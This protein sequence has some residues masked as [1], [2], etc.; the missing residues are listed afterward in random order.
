MKKLVI[1]LMVFSI[2]TTCSPKVSTPEYQIEYPEDPSKKPDSNNSGS[3]PNEPI[4]VDPDD[5]NLPFRD[6]VKKYYNRGSTNFYFGCTPHNYI[7]IADYPKSIEITGIQR[8]FSY[9]TPDN[10][11]KQTLLH[12]SP[13]VYASAVNLEK[14]KNWGKFA[15]DNGMVIR[16]HGPASPQCSEWASTTGRTSTELEQNLRE[17]I[18]YLFEII[19]PM[20]DVVKW[21]D[22][23]NE[24]ISTGLV[25]D[26][27]APGNPKP[28]L[29]P[30][31]SW[32][33]PLTSNTAFQNPWPIIG[34]LPADGFPDLIKIGGV[35]KYI[36]I[37]FE[38]ATQKASPNI[39]LL[40]NQHGANFGGEI[41][42]N[43]K[44][45]VNYLRSRGYRVDA[46]G[47]QA[48]VNLGWTETQSNLDNLSSF[49]D[50]CHENDLEFHLTEVNINYTNEAQFLN[51]ERQANT[52]SKLIETVLKKRHTGI[53]GVNF[54]YYHDESSGT[55]VMMWR[56]DGSPRPAVQRVKQMLLDNVNK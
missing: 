12:P 45:L 19:N 43:M 47:W 56:P 7:A 46:V 21:V 16:A 34:M 55:K 26:N 13:G 49:I 50:W 40:I 35:P 10:T 38:L 6:I 30:A 29:Y 3:D 18:D 37:A 28:Q 42:K 31:G 25:T 52:F 14:A 44:S 9:I 11:Y 41:W 27:Q 2:F 23:I 5:L 24:T 36:D 8:E 53:V 1:F 20:D 54:W 22:V 15:R 4:E 33:G 17:F 51:E 39:K 48:H 32:F